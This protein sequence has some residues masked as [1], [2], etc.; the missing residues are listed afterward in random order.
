MELRDSLKVT[1]KIRIS[2]YRAGFV[3]AVAP[4]LDAL[5][6]YRRLLVQ[7]PTEENARWL[8]E[9]VERL[10]ETLKLIREEHFIRTAVECP[11]LVMDS[12]GYGLDLIIQRL[13]GNNTFSLNIGWIEIG[14][15]TATPTVND[16]ALTSPSVRATISYQEDYGA[17]DAI[18]QAYITDANLPNG[19]YTEVGSFIDGTSS[20]GSGQIFNHAL[21]SPVYGKVSGED[22]TI[23]IDINVAN[24]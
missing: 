11:N 21:L 16:T 9:K 6:D 4:Y 5:Q 17:T 15:G 8:R 3:E 1:G 7:R 12:P 23:E 13:I 22:T 19:T 18:V 24:A 14:T 20:I 10:T 2:T